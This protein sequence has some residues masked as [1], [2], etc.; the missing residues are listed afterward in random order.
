[1]FGR[2]VPAL[3]MQDSA[4]VSTFVVGAIVVVMGSG[5]TKYAEA[6]ALLGSTQAEEG[7]QRRTLGSVSKANHRLS[8]TLLTMAVVAQVFARA[9]RG[10]GSAR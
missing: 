3:R 9:R 10:R 6:I 4:A 7:Q 5:Y 1:M 8:A 2:D